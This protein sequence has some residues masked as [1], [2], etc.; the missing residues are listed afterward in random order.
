MA[1]P[2][3]VVLAINGA[4]GSGK[5]SIINLIEHHT[6]TESSI[7]IL[8]FNPWWYSG[9]EALT[10]AFFRE[11]GQILDKSIGSQAKSAF[12][13]IGAR[14]LRTAGTVA[15]IVDATGVGGA[16][17][18]SV[19]ALNWAADF[20]SDDKSLEELHRE[21]SENL[22]R[23]QCRF[24]VIIDDIDRLDPDA[25]LAI[26]RLVKS[27]GQLPNVIYLLSF[28]RSLAESAVTRRFPSEGSYYLEKIIQVSFDIPKIDEEELYRFSLNKIESIVGAI[29]SD[30]QVDFLNLYHEVV[31]PSLKTPRDAFKLINSLSVTYPSVQGEVDVGDFVAIESLRIFEPMLYRR[32][33]ENGSLLTAN[34]RIG[35]D[36]ST[37][38]KQQA[39]TNALIGDHRDPEWAQRVLRRLFPVCDAVWANTYHTSS[40]SI[41][42]RRRRACAPNHF[43]TYFRF[44][45]SKKAVSAKVLHDFIRSDH[46]AEWIAEKAKFYAIPNESGESEIARILDGLSAHGPEIPISRATHMLNGFFSVADEIYLATDEARGMSFADNRLRLHWLLRSILFDR[47]TLLERSEILMAAMANAQT[48]WMVDFARSAWQDWHPRKGKEATSED[49][50]LLTLKDTETIRLAVLDRLRSEASSGRLLHE[51]ALPFLLYNWADFSDVKPS[52]VREWTS[53]LLEG[54]ET[55]L[56]FAEQFTADSWSHSIGFHGLGDLVAKRSTRSTLPDADL[57]VDLEALKGRLIE[58][59]STSS[60]EGYKNRAAD[61]L[62]LWEAAG[63]TDD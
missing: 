52:E 45:L 27:V 49:Q 38:Q 29:E 14:I 19:G 2:E 3:G 62:A 33:R 58:I 54:V 39:W 12:A 40:G 46:D 57:L 26:F 48:V 6:K 50:C 34:P 9:E 1:A 56:L 31:A 41:W 53:K 5:T 22:K 44:S 30:R 25:A 55:T 61:I 43:E 47:T 24:L 16:A 60:D 20:L 10:V 63:A 35:G 21:I 15:P 23:Q 4:W 13:R 11:I 36:Y 42:L 8:R 59:K 28:D 51:R 17:T 37:T 32:I 7:K 18:A